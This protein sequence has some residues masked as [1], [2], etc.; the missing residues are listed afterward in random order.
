MA[1]RS[2]N[3][4]KEAFTGDTGSDRGPSES[5]W[6]DC[7]WLELQNNPFKGFFFQDDFQNSVS[8]VA[9]TAWVPATTNALGTTGEWTGGT[10]ATT[11]SVVPVA[12]NKFGEIQI[13]SSTANDDSVLAWPK[14][15]DLAG[16]FDFT[17]GQ[18]I[19]MEARVKFSTITNAEMGA[20]IGFAE[21][22]LV[23]T[24][25][26]MSATN[27]ALSDKDY[28]GFWKSEA[29]GDAIKQL[30]N[31]E[32]GAASPNTATNDV[33][34]VADTYVKLG[35]KL[36]SNGRLTFYKNGVKTGYSVTVGTTD[37]PDGEEMAFYMG[38]M[39][40]TNDDESMTVDWVRLAQEF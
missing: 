4:A 14:T 1:I 28:I 18:K 40:G 37:F 33:V 15:A 30:W 24:T 13:F 9:G 23:D 5:I 11:G 36:T 35:M 39:S 19:W 20:F 27:S 25:E 8:L 32:S 21:E 3:L 10:A 6:K 7:P 17:S 12:T 2:R 38:V 26:L 31:T 29:D 16:P 22:G 34:P